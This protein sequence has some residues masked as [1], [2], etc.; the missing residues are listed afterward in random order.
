M[1]EGA[2]DG[3]AEQPRRHRLIAAR[4]ARGLT[5]PQLVI[6]LERHAWHEMKPPMTR[7]SVSLRSYQNWE[8][9]HPA[10]LDSQRVLSS[11]FGMSVEALGFPPSPILDDPC[12]VRTPSPTVAVSEALSDGPDQ[13]D[14]EVKR[15]QFTASVVA[16]A[17]LPGAAAPTTA[18]ASS[19]PPA[20]G[21][22]SPATIAQV[23][24]WSRMARQMDYVHGGASVRRAVVPELE[25]CAEL[26]AQT[27]PASLRTPLLSALAEFAD[28]SGYALLDTLD[29]AGAR[30]AFSF[31]L[32]CAQEADD[33]NLR[34][35]ILTD[36][37]CQALWLENPDDAR[38]FTELAL[39][40][41]DRLTATAQ[42]MAQAARARALA[43]AGLADEALRAVAASDEAFARRDPSEDP[44]W[45]AYYSLAQQQ[46][47]TAR[48][49]HDLAV[50]GHATDARVRYEQA[51]LGHGE[52]RLRARATSELKLAALTMTTGD[53]HEAAA[54]GNRAL[55]TAE[56]VT[57]RRAV[58]H[59]TTLARA[60]KPHAGM[61]DVADLRERVHAY[62]T[63]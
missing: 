57:S 32:A 52:S 38:T 35:E 39:V 49:M 1:T 54:L 36:M 16:L 18:L 51:A 55:A 33:W 29:H 46:G 20:R 14:D 11:F 17:G 23:R 47:D 44:H 40:R 6:A 22:I 26:L 59:A 12:T 34:A 41:P 7:W 42:A 58:E 28:V 62:T 27:C 60:A 25:H 30:Q 63:A 56:Q 48:T 9:G 4:V 8:Y 45:L 3:K 50:Q 43:H 5:Q 13:E 21:Q 19:T 53:P 15:R 61:P 10:R 24:D 37:A 2:S 31:G